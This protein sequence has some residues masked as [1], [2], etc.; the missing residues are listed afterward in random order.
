MANDALPDGVVIIYGLQD[1]IT[2]ELRYVGKTQ[3]SLSKRRK[4]HLG[5]S[6]NRLVIEWVAHL[7]ALN[8]L[9]QAFEIERV[10][11]SDW[12]EAECFWVEYFRSIGC[13]LLNLAPP[14]GGSVSHSAEV[15]ALMS[16]RG[17]KLMAH[18][19]QRA[20]R[21]EKAHQLWG[22]LFHRE[23]VLRAIAE[24]VKRPE[25]RKM[26][27]DL[28]RKNWQD[29]NYRTKFKESQAHLDRHEIA[30]G[31]WNRPEYRERHRLAREARKIRGWITEEQ[32]RK[33]SAA[34]KGRKQSPEQIAK[35][36]AARIGLKLS[37]ETKAKIS[38]KAKQRYAQKLYWA[39]GV[40]SLPG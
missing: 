4:Q 33:Q 36:A 31:F 37:D 17:K 6:K 25:V 21:R 11:D 26:R 38:A 23:K 30:K 28:K 9:P 29:P 13:Q 16:E 34:L 39:R 40:L 12:V 32:K 7:R 10:T 18:P 5:H 20:I 19:A 3:H 14:G 2:T 8:T 22:D 35:S 1:P 15:R 24:S 27:S